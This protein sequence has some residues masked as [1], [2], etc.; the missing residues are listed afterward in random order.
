VAIEKTS[1][2]A[3]DSYVALTGEGRDVLKAYWKALRQDPQGIRQLRRAHGVVMDR[4]HLD[5]IRLLSER[6]SRTAGAS[7]RAGRRVHGTGRRVATSSPHQSPPTMAPSSRCSCPF[8]PVVA[9]MPRLNRYYAATF[10][11]SSVESPRKMEGV[12]PVWL[13]LRGLWLNAA[14]PEIPAGTDGVDRRAALAMGRFSRLA[15]AWV[16]PESRAGCGGRPCR[17]APIGGLLAPNMTLGVMFSAA[18]RFDG[19]GRTARSP[20]AREADERGPATLRR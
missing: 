3:A 2:Q 13:L 9:V 6:F 8:V 17:S 10:G 15:L 18:G 16:L 5:R 7:R 19:G 1:R 14:I 12:F 4:H 20:L 11:T